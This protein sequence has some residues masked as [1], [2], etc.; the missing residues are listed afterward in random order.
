MNNPSPA[1]KRAKKEKILRNVGSTCTVILL[2]QQGHVGE[3]SGWL[4]CEPARVAEVL[5]IP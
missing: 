2:S 4:T 1:R 3:L 5:K